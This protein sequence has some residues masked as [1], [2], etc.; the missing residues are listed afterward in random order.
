MANQPINVMLVDDHTTV[1]RG[2]RVF[3]DEY[4][5]ICVI[6]E[7]ANGVEAIELVKKIKPD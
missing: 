1:R 2:I 3:L 7:A 4:E 6:G 5:D